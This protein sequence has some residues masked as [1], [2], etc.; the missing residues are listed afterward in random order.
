ML[1]TRL[2]HSTYTALRS[3][4]DITEIVIFSDSE[5]ALSWLATFPPPKT[6]GVMIN[7]RV[8]EIRKIVSSLPISIHYGYVKTDLN[9]AHCAARGM[10]MSDF[11]DHT[12]WNGPTFI[13]LAQDLWPDGCRL[14]LLPQEPDN[15][16]AYIDLRTCVATIA[17]VLRFLR[18]LLQKMNVFLRSRNEKRILALCETAAGEFI[19]V[20][21]R[22]R[23]LT[24]LMRNHQAVYM[25]TQRRTV[26]KQLELYTD[27][28]GV[29]RCRERM[30]NAN[31]ELNSRQAIHIETKTP[32]A[33]A[34]VRD[35][36]TR[37]STEPS[38][39]VPQRDFFIWS[40]IWPR[41]LF[42]T[43]FGDSLHRDT[44]E[45][46]SPITGHTFCSPN[47]FYGMPWFQLSMTSFSQ[48]DGCRGNRMEDNHPI[49]PVA[50]SVCERLIKSVKHSLCKV[51][52][53]ANIT[54]ETLETLLVEVEGTLNCRSL[55]YQG[56][57]W[58]NTPVLRPIDFIQRDMLNDS[59]TQ[60]LTS[61]RET[62]KLDISKKRGGNKIPIR[63]EIVL[64]SDPGL[65]RNSWKMERIVNLPEHNGTIREA[66][67]KMPNG[68]TLRRPIK[69]FVSLELGK[70]DLKEDTSAN[71][72]TKSTI[73]F[74]RIPNLVTILAHDEK[75][76]MTT[77]TS[78]QV[79]RISSSIFVLAI[80]LLKIPALCA[81]VPPLDHAKRSG[82]E[83]RCVQGEAQLQASHVQ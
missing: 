8:T 45:P 25:L 61:L 81:T 11:H 77:E 51:M 4:I 60:Y 83:F 34:I 72:T 32:L 59:G 62:H 5:I 54:K 17:Y 41:Q 48:N 42:S 75:T 68:R 55:T 35:N 53:G 44:L 66:E 40:A 52:R 20:P 23:A 1:A 14:F 2:A 78:V 16:E 26:L 65:P 57:H 28:H 63:D 10:K 18:Q 21:E 71:K 50:G 39:P 24:V 9:A 79:E 64:V 37:K 82:F 76:V 43:P 58:D 3:R 69:L 46:S 31:M 33:K 67:L 19:T 7:N 47:R 27:S 38:L 73:P 30:N 49:R 80:A 36:H 29:I 22:E 13:T 6:A 70:A 12:W 56:E 74:R 15:E